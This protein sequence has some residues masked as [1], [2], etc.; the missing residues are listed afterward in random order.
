MIW[1]RDY[2]YHIVRA[3]TV[4]ARKGAQHGPTTDSA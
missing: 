4:I 2:T 3:D 1:D